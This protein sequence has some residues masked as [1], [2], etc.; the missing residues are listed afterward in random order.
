MV[1]ASE[2]Y[3]LNVVG[4]LGAGCRQWGP[5]NLWQP[6]C[7]PAWWAE[8]PRSAVPIILRVSGPYKYGVHRR[9]A[10]DDTC[11]SAFCFLMGGHVKMDLRF[12]QARRA[13]RDAVLYY[14][15]I[16]VKL[17]WKSWNIGYIYVSSIYI[18]GIYIYIYYYLAW[19]RNQLGN[20]VL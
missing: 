12:W 6:A 15:Y 18:L 10:E 8:H 13:G 11:I 17:T 20:Y 5:V 1:N 7:V 3:N 14:I 19:P 2:A 4:R 16:Y 9:A